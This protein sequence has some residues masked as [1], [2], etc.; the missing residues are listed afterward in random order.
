MEYIL[1]M[2]VLDVTLSDILTILSL[3]GAAIAGWILREFSIINSK[4]DKLEESINRY[5]DNTNEKTTEMKV[6]VGKIQTS[7]K[8]IEEMIKNG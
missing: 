2:N 6:D 7:I 1:K 3:I 4:H 8:N 5:M